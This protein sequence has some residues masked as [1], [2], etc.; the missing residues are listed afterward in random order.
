MIKGTL[1]LNFGPLVFFHQTTPPRPLRHGLKPFSIY[2]STGIRRENRL[3]NRQ[4]LSQQSLA[5]MM[6]KVTVVSYL[7]SGVN[8]SDEKS[9]ELNHRKI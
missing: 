5:K 9:Q 4:F 1:T 7:H 8:D 6:S 3:C 2:I